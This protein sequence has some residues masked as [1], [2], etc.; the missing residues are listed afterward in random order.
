MAGVNSKS[1]EIPNDNLETFSIFWLD[2]QVNATEDNRN[3]QLKLRE[4]INHLKTF[5]DLG[6][7]YQRILSLSTQDRLVLIVSGRCGRQLVPQ[8]HHL[9]QVS[10]IYVYCMDKKANELE[11]CLL[12]P[13]WEQYIIMISSKVESCKPDGYPAPEPTRTWVRVKF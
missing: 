1:L 3:T 13:P 5:D 4:I 7:C 2:K 6:E 11:S 10:S 8:I 9:R 12:F